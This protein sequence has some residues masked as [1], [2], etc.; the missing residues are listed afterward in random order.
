[1]DAFIA[2]RS[3]NAA[4]LYCDAV[5]VSDLREWMA[6]HVRAKEVAAKEWN[7]A[8]GRDGKLYTD[9]WNDCRTAML[10]ASKERTE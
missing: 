3:T 7:Q 9:G 10:A 5:S 6:G 1:M 8:E 4:D 2:A